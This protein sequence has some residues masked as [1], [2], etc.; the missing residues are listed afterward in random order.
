LN[1]ILMKSRTVVHS[2]EVPRV[3]VICFSN[4]WGH[5]YIVGD[6]DR[7][8]RFSGRTYRDGVPSTSSGLLWGGLSDQ[9]QF[10]F[11]RPTF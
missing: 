1:G 6:A 9:L 2:L 11:P 3:L 5:N 4:E 10:L 7:I 8:W